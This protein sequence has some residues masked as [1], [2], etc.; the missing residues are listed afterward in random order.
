MDI[1]L[2][3]ENAHELFTNNLLGKSGFQPTI[4]TEHV[5][6]FTK[7]SD[8]EV[9]ETINQHNKKITE[10]NEAHLSSS[11]SSSSDYMQ[12]DS[13]TTFYFASLTVV[14]LYIVFQMIKK[15]R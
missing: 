13:I 11:P 5:Y 12:N 1:I 15:T 7:K 2:Q 4:D 9:F 8:N 14:G 3:K 6:V 10:N